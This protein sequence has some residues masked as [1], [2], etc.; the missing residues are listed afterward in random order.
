MKIRPRIV[1]GE[2]PYELNI[3]SIVSVRLVETI[4]PAR[5]VGGQWPFDNTIN[6][7]ASVGLVKIYYI[8]TSLVGRK[9]LKGMNQY[10]SVEYCVL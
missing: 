6:S 10:F 1:G 5:I 8:D 7:I 2:W 3:N 9:L 4:P